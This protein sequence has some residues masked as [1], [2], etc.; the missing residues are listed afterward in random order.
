MCFV[1]IWWFVASA[2]EK[3]RRGK[4]SGYLLLD[5]IYNSLCYNSSEFL[6][7]VYL[8]EKTERAEAISVMVLI[9]RG[10]SRWLPFFLLHIAL[11]FFYFFFFSMCWAAGRAWN[12]WMVSPNVYK[13]VYITGTLLLLDGRSWGGC[14]VDTEHGITD[15][16]MEMQS[17]GGRDVFVWRWW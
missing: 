3:R 6:D 2:W 16:E 10:I 12:F 17:K 8:D 11:F 15:I 4:T 7:C 9:K 5:W 14:E 1:W 13:N